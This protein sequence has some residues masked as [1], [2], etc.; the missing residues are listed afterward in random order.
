MSVFWFFIKF[1]KKSLTQ[2]GGV[3]APVAGKIFSEILPYLNIEKENE[4]QINEIKVPDL[5]GKS[6]KEAE[7]ILKENNL[8]IQL[9]ENET[10]KE[11]IITKQ[12]PEKDVTIK[13]GSSIIVHTN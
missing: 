4:E 2:G 9:D 10:D 6:I 13:E 3:A 8:E 1:N 5:I 11:K 7:K 12:I